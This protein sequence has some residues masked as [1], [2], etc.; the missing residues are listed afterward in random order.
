MIANYL[1]RHS[2]LYLV[3]LTLLIFVVVRQ[4]PVDYTDGDSEHV[5]LTAQAIVQHGTVKLDAYVT[6][7]YGG[8]VLEERGHLYSYQPLGTSFFAVPLVWLANLRG[9]D[10]SDRA[11]HGNWQ[12]NLAA[13]TVSACF[14]L[15]YLISRRFS[16]AA[17][18]LVL[19]SVFT[20]GSSIAANMGAALTN[21]N[22]AMVFALMALLLIV[23]DAQEPLSARWAYILGG[24]LFAAYFARPTMLIAV[25][26]VFVYLL[27]WRRPLLSRA[28]VGLALPLAPFLAFS[29]IEYGQLLPFYYRIDRLNLPPTLLRLYGLVLSPARGLLVYNPFLL[30]VLFGLAIGSRR[31]VREPLFWLAATWIVLD[32]AA[33]SRWANWWGGWSFGSRLL[34]DTMPALLLLTLLVWSD[35]QTHWSPATRRLIAATFLLL[36][37]FGI[38]INTSQGLYNPWTRDWNVWYR[39]G[40][41]AGTRYEVYMLDWRYPHFLASP[42]QVSRRNLEYALNEQ[43][44]LRLNEAVGPNSEKIVFRGWQDVDPA[45]TDPCRWSD[46]ASSDIVFR[47]ETTSDTEARDLALEVTAG[48]HSAQTVQVLL[49]KRLL[50]VISSQAHWDPQVYSFSLD[51]GRLHTGAEGRQVNELR[52]LIPGAFSPASSDPAKQ[53]MRVLGLCLWQFQIRSQSA[54]EPSP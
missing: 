38:F 34:L 12:R 42:D 48:T 46:G 37:A 50:G 5:L 16:G 3:L 20:L 24:L 45:G 23:R 41:N 10:M 29:W 36:A 13:I 1:Q 44:P 30:A 14:V 35:A 26:V 9:H 43:G 18:S 40:E 6:Q 33:L 19:A 27:L 52:F 31:L 54:P 32:L 22:L 15:S 21:H 25:V 4:A 7:A 49:N 17:A 8:K 51:A 2:Q 39:A 11:T 28:A 47:I 53:D